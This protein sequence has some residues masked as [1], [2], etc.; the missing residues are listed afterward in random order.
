MAFK[1]L[2]SHQSESIPKAGWTQ[3]LFMTKQKMV[4]GEQ[5][6]EMMPIRK[7]KQL[8]CKMMKKKTQSSSLMSRS[9]GKFFSK[10]AEWLREEEKIDEIIKHILD[11]G[12]L[13]GDRKYIPHGPVLSSKYNNKSKS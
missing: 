10:K 6:Q 12:L 1:L 3:S 2:S 7:A 4:Q 8:I 9:M 11:K 13:V 5:H